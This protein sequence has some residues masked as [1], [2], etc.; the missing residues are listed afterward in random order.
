MNQ[1]GCFN[2]RL[3]LGRRRG[4]DYARAS[5]RGG[6]AWRLGERTFRKMSRAT[7]QRRRP[8]APVFRPELKELDALR[9]VESDHQV[10]GAVARSAGAIIVARPGSQWTSLTA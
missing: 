9:I 1:E 7:G 10:F 6:A 2:A 3:R 8:A 4:D 5:R